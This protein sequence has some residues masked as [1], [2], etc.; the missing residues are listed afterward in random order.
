[1]SV[2]LG[3]SQEKDRESVFR[4]RTDCKARLVSLNRDGLLLFIF[5]EERRLCNL[6]LQINRIVLKRYL[7]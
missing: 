3:G 4:H 1:V 6:P 7:K 5:S 2:T